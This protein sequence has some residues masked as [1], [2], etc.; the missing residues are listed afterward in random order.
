[1]LAYT[2]LLHNQNSLWV[3]VCY[4]LKADGGDEWGKRTLGQPTPL[5]GKVGCGGR[6]HPT[7]NRQWC[8]RVRGGN[9]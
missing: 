5:A 2:R 7:C 3:V 4:V 1:V 9:T 6:Q 8:L